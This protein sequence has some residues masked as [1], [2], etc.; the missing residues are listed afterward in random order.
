MILGEPIIPVAPGGGAGGGVT[1]HGALTGLT[2]DD[3]SQYVHISVARTI[4]ATHTFNPGIAGPFVTLG[5]NATGQLVTGLNSDLLD[6]STAADFAPVSHNHAASAITSGQLALARGGTNTDMS[7]TGGSGHLVR[8]NSAGGTFT[9]A[10]LSSSDFGANILTS[11]QLAASVTDETGSGLLVFATSP[12]L[13]TPNIGTPSAGVLTNCTGLPAS[14]LVAGI[15]PENAYLGAVAATLSAD[16]KFWGITTE[17][18]AGATLAFGDLVYRAAADSRWELADADDAATSG[19]VVL[20][21]CVL[22]AAGDGSATR[23]LR[24]GWVRADTAFPTFT[25]SGPVYVGT[26]AGDVQTTQPSGT[27]DV[28]RRV[29]FAE[30]ADI[31]FFNPSPDY[32]THT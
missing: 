10:A 7:A 21:I 20:G 30:T 17:E 31:L 29:G 15:I 3:H 23:I 12:V 6:G 9:T 4:T 11:A 27:D 2:D 8:Q 1:D 14:A 28:I 13:T 26:T 5:T 32:I 16:G 24:L 18:T 25:V 22:A 19:D